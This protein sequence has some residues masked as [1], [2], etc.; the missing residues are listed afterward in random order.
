M[1][2][3]NVMNRAIMAKKLYNSPLIEVMSLSTE[4]L[5]HLS[6]T[7]EGTDNFPE[8]PAGAPKTRPF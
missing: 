5:Q 1:E 8:G 4:L 7:S 6:S 2:K 3:N